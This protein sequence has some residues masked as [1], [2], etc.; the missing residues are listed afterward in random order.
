MAIASPRK[1]SRNFP[2]A[3]EAF[4]GD[5]DMLL[6]KENPKPVFRQVFEWVRQIAQ[7]HNRTQAGK[8]NNLG[9][10]TVGTSSATTTLVD[11]RIGAKSIIHFHPTT[12]NGAAEIATLWQTYPNVTKGQAVINHVNSATAGRTFA[13]TVFG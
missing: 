13:Y 7:T 9:T 1:D 5:L 11:R 4:Y 6:K 3:P 12:A 8:T 2:I 10:F